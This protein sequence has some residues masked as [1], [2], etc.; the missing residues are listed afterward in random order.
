MTDGMTAAVFGHDGECISMEI[1]HRF[2]AFR[3]RQ[4]G[5]NWDKI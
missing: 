2:V 4:E 5:G 1:A 3:L